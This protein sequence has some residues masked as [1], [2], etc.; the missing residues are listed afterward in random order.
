[1]VITPKPRCNNELVSMLSLLEFITP[2]D[3]VLLTEQILICF[4]SFSSKG[5]TLTH[6]AYMLV[7]T[8][9]ATAIHTVSL[10]LMVHLMRLIRLVPDS[11]CLVIRKH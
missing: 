2:L 4:Y 1:M 10:D 9:P 3:M 6:S 7:A 5:C 11:Y 8:C